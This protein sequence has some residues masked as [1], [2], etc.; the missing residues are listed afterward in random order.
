M[1]NTDDEQEGQSGHRAIIQDSW[2]RAREYIRRAE[3]ADVDPSRAV[4]P[5]GQETIAQQ[6]ALAAHSAVIQFRD[7]IMPFREARTKNDIKAL[8]AEEFT[9]F[10]L[11]G[12]DYGVSLATLNEWTNQ[13]LVEQDEVTD[14]VMGQQVETRKYRILLPVSVCREAYRHI[15]RC[16]HELGFT[17]ETPDITPEDDASPEDLKGL[18]IQRGQEEAAEQLPDRFT[19]GRSES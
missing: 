11:Q 17:A 13:H 7:D 3:A 19:A 6:H 2:Q 16:A 10:T 9:E 4:W 12:D 1:N 14:P 15:L 5:A 8:W 18:L